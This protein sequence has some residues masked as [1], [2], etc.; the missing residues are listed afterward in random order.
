MRLI[1]SALALAAIAAPVAAEPG[2]ETVTVR[3]AYADIDL[4][5][6]E[7]RAAFEQRVEA[8]LRAACT[9]ETN[10]RYGYGQD[11]VDESCVNDARTA[12]LAAAERIAANQSRS[13]REVAAN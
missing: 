13:G 8:E 1:L 10:S 2:E 7:G 11:I 4:T 6:A 12:A 3:I 9:I 5:S